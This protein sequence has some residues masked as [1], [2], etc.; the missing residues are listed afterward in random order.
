MSTIGIT[1]KQAHFFDLSLDMLCIADFD[2]HFKQVNPAWE[3]VTGFS[4][5][6]LVAKPFIE[7]VHP[8][9]HA[10]TIKETS[11]LCDAWFINTF[12]NY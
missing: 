10:A 1:E 7:F 9:D 2:G 6:E 8:D 5:H 4:H 12:L 3:P 11:L